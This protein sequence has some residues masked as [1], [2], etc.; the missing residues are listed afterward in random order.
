MGGRWKL[1][2]HPGCVWGEKFG[3]LT[4]ANQDAA[5]FKEICSVIS[6]YRSVL[7]YPISLSDFS[8]PDKKA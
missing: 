4:M 8:V 3:I 7:S 2:Q 6:V 5:G 1:K